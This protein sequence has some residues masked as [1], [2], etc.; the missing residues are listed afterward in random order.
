MSAAGAMV[1]CGLFSSAVFARTPFVVAAGSV[2][3]TAA[4]SVV[5]TAAG[6]VPGTAAGGAAAGPRS[7]APPPRTTTRPAIPRSRCRVTVLWG[8]PPISSWGSPSTSPVFAPSLASRLAPRQRPLP[9]LLSP[10]SLSLAPLSLSLSP[11]SPFSL[12]FSLFALRSQSFVFRETSCWLWL[13]CVI[14]LLACSFAGFRR[15]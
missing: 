3:G 12:P 6:R 15:R 4:G 1:A 2:V 7:V 11:L 13:D 14:C 10:F 9:P 8:S 5:G